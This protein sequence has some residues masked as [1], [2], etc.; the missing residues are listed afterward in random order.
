MKDTIPWLIWH[1]YSC[2][3][4]S[5]L[6]LFTFGML[7]KFPKQFGTAMVSGRSIEA[8]DY[9]KLI[10]TIRALKKKASYE[11]VFE[12][13]GWRYKKRIDNLP[14]GTSGMVTSVV[15]ALNGLPNIM[16]K[17]EQR[18][19]C[20][21]VFCLL[22]QNVLI[23]EKIWNMPFPLDIED[24]S[25]EKCYNRKFSEGGLACFYCNNG[26]RN[27][28]PPIEAEPEFLILVLDFTE[29][30]SEQPIPLNKSFIINEDFTSNLSG[31]KYRFIGSINV[32]NAGHFSCTLMDP[33]FFDGKEAKGLWHHDDLLNQ[34]EI[35]RFSNFIE[36][37]SLNPYVLIY[38]KE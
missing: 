36:L 27:F 15:S 29:S 22:K 10:A 13:W 9:R 38:K 19:E 24:T 11:P 3:Y 6:T 14:T 20:S 30:H 1:R 21:N 7:Y 17:Y 25:V 2:R 37:L 33:V 23:E 18:K 5:F 32:P 8:T 35:V 26:T 12:Y 34:G 4:D 16:K 28:M 31:N